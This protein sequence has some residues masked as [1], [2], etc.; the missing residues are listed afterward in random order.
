MPGKERPRNTRQGGDP[1][2]PVANRDPRDIEEIER[3]QQRIRE[4]EIRQDERNEETESNSVVWDDGFD[5]EENP[6]GRRPPPQARSQNHGD[7]LR[8]LGVRVEIPKFTGT[9]QLDE[10]I[11]WISTVERVF[12]LRDIPDN[13]KVKVVAIKLRKYA[14]LWQDAFLEY[15]SLMQNNSSVEQFIADFDRLRMR[16]GVDEDEE[17]QLVTFVDDTT[18]EF[19]TDGEDGVAPQDEQVV[20]PDQGES[21]AVQRVL[22]ATVDKTGDDTLWLRNNI[23]RTKRTTKGNVCIVII[24]RG[25]YDN[26]VATTMVD[27]LGLSVQDHPEPYQLT[28]L[29]RECL[30]LMREIK[31]CIDFLPGASIPNKPAYRM[32]PK[33]FEE[34]HRQVTELLAKGLIRE[35]MSPYAVPA[36][37][38]SKHGGAY[39]LL[40]Q[41]HDTKFFSKIDLRSVYQQIRLRPGDEWK[42]AI[43]TRDGLYE[44]MVMPF[45]LSNAPST[46][47][48][49]M[50]H[51]FCDFIGRF[52][53]VYFED[54]LIF[55]PNIQQHLQYLRDVFIVLKDQKLFANHGKCHFLI[56]EIVFLG[57]LISGDG[58]QMDKTKVHAITSSPPPKTLHDVRSFHGLDSFYRGFIRN[59]STIVAP[60]T[61]CL[62]GSSFVW[63]DEAQ[64]AFDDLKIRVT[65]ALVLALPNFHEV[66]Q[67]ECDASGL[68]NGGVLSQGK[69]PIAFF[70]EKLNETRRKYSTYDK[71]F[72]AIIQNALSRSHS[73]LTSIHLQV[74]GFDV[75]Q[76]LYIDDLD[77]ASAWKGCPAPPFHKFIKHDGFL[78]KNNRLC[79]PRCSLRDAITL[80][81]HQGGLGGHFGRDKTVGLIRDR[82]YWPNVVKDVSRIVELLNRPWE[83]VSIDFVLGLPHTQRQKD[84]IMVVVDRFSKMAHFVPCAKTYNASQVAR[85]YFYEII[86]LHA[87][88]GTIRNKGIWYY[89]KPNLPTTGPIMVPQYQKRAN[90]HCKRVVFNEGDLVWIH[91]HKECFS[92]GRFGKL[93]PRGDGPFNVLKRINDN[94]YK[95]ELPGHYNV[96]ATFNVGDLTRYVPLDDDDVDVVDS[97]SSPFLDREDDV[98]PSLATNTFGFLHSDPFDILGANP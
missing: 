47:M 33:E 43:K 2:E 78:F 56:T 90:Q 60:I 26:M 44:W 51:I 91:L 13:L 37:L 95:I 36:L 61:E 62:K 41:L 52:V 63:T 94:A 45:G 66:F 15:H 10:F 69:R 35:S 87:L 68:A 89:L 23:F 50:N 17:Q 75:F 98:D 3:L 46:F 80:E 70:S 9:S 76:H 54:I 67:V 16:C 39:H 21:L 64:Q 86:R 29:K 7:I 8:S 4:L 40:D 28:W 14:S 5:G 55:S 59:F 83:D 97:R 32:N 58:I 84:S 11:D 34:L 18:C 88:L 12:D 73:L 71:E 1:A 42:T 49:L 65:S 79:V 82:F 31:H 20:Y 19:D 25:S 27:R 81:Y 74:Y 77:F 6:F 92:R 85:L 24:D 57:Y 22:S 38:V 53:V 93:Q 30:P 96:F 48:G 72:Y